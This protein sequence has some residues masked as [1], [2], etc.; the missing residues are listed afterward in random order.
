MVD[1]QLRTV[2]VMIFCGYVETY[3]SSYSHIIPAVMTT[4]GL[5]EEFQG[6]G[7][8]LWTVETQ[9]SDVFRYCGFSGQVQILMTSVVIF[10]YI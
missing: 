7:G 2:C 10:H 4:R 1:S 3:L 9:K 6:L 8:H 5:T